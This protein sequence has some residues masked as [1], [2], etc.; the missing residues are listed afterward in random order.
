MYNAKE[1]N[2]QIIS[3]LKEISKNLK[4]K[5]DSKIIKNNKNKSIK[6]KKI[7]KEKNEKEINKKKKK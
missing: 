1:L 3:N 7:N 6:N 2:I 4:T 5:Y